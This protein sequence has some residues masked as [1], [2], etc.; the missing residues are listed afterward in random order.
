MQ[1]IKLKFINI[2]Y[3]RTVALPNAQTLFLYSKNYKAKLFLLYLPH[4]ADHG[5]ASDLFLLYLL[6]GCVCVI[7][8]TNVRV[9]C[10]IWADRFIHKFWINFV[11]PW[12]GYITV[13]TIIVSIPPKRI[14]CFQYTSH[15]HW[16]VNRWFEPIEYQPL[17]KWRV[18][19]GIPF[20]VNR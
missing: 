4:I 6:A 1:T 18:N 10:R 5:A 11:V 9:M 7:S 2:L 19:H 15:S 17:Q 16:N 13:T 14:I 20:N 8:R 12:C 3:L